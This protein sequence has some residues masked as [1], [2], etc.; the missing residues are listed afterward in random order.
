MNTISQKVSFQLFYFHGHLIT[1]ILNLLFY[2]KEP[3][4]FKEKL[5]C[6]QLETISL[7]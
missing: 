6:L 2:T 1:F 4:L 3:S 7:T 5:L